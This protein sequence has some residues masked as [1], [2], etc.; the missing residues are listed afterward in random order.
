MR[1][2]IRVL[3]VN[4]HLVMEYPPIQQQFVT[5]TVLVYRSIPVYVTKVTTEVI[6]YHLHVL[7]YPNQI[8]AY[9][10][11][12]VRVSHQIIVRAGLI[13]MEPNAKDFL[14]T[15]FQNQDQM[16]VMVEA[17]VSTIIHV[18]AMRAILVQIAS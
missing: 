3:I 17:H 16:F 18:D 7:D 8:A 10:V 6:A 5:V 4:T 14:V 13:T 15:E 1:S 11:Q 2:T 12:V 9:V